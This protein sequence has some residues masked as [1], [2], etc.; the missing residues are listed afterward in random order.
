M[1]N[2]DVL[3]QVRSWLEKQGFVFEMEVARYFLPHCKYADAGHQYIDPVSGKVR[4]TD[5]FCAWHTSGPHG[6]LHSVYLV[7]ECKNTTAPWVFFCD[8]LKG[9]IG[10][11]PRRSAGELE[12]CDYCD[13]NFDRLFD[14]DP[15]R[16]QYAYAITEKRSDRATRDLA[17]EA[18]LSVV[19][20]SIAAV[21]HS[22]QF[23][24]VNYV[25]HAVEVVPLVV[26]RSPL[27]ACRLD[28]F[29]IPELFEVE[30]CWVRQSHE[31]VEDPVG[32]L[33]LTFD[34]LHRF[35]DDFTAVMRA[36]EMA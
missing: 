23:D 30:R 36:A 22:E 13:R 3:Q 27:V 35:V 29:G 5:L 31:S 34:S 2:D 11:R 16:T 6:V 21:R 25:H 4:E 33:V 32:V 19:S 18:I 15:Y 9:E 14:I 8:S 20:A 1:A 24:E 12:R 26:T 10:G 28:K 7:V 17:R